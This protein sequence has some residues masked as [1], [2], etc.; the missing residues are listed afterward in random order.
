MAGKVKY[1]HENEVTNL[2]SCDGRHYT[3]YYF[4]NDHAGYSRKLYFVPN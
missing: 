3:Y 2:V 1:L 4:A